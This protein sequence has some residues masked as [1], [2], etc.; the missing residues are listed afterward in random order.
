M[1]RVESMLAAKARKSSSV[2]RET[3]VDEP[4]P[5]AYV[6]DSS[7]PTSRSLS[8]QPTSSS[9]LDDSFLL[10]RVHSSGE[11]SDDGGTE[12]DEQAAKEV[13]RLPGVDFQ[14]AYVKMI[15][16]ILMDTFRERFGLT[17]VSVA[18]EAGMVVGFNEKSIRTWRNDFYENHGDFSESNKGICD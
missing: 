16:L 3:V 4:Q 12:F 7:Q 6:A 10:P 2:S 14:P 17:D 5:N 8:V 11:E 15:S 9:S 13:L 18:S 1:S